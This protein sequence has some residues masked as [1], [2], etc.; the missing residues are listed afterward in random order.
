MPETYHISSLLVRAHPDRLADVKAAI[1]QIESAEIAATDPTGKIIVT[2]ETP[3]DAEIVAA[4]NRVET[5]AGVA[6]AALVFHHIE[7][8]G[9]DS[10]SHAGDP[11]G[12][13]RETDHDR[14]TP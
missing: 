14:F 6:S 9:A 8:D 1:E 3:G 4:L 5:L 12:F 10:P 13:T 11:A 7:T 2:L